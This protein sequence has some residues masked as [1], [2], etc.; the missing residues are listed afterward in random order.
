MA[1]ALPSIP[2]STPIQNRPDYARAE[3]THAKPARDLCGALMLGTS[4]VR[5]LGKIGLPKWPAEKEEH[6]KIRAAISQ[7]ARYYQRTVQASVGMICATPPALNKDA[8]PLLLADAEDIDGQG[9]H[10]EVFSKHLTS[11]AITGGFSAILVDAPPIPEGMSLSLADEQALGIRPF[12]VPIPADRIVSWIV[13]TPKFADL[14]ALWS[15]GLITSDQVKSAAKQTLLRQVVI[16]EPTDVTAGTYGTVCK[17][18]Y[19]ALRLTDDGVT[20]EV[21]EKRTSDGATGEHFALIASGP[22]YA[23]GRQA[24]REIPLA[25]VYGGRKVAPF[26]AEPALMA[27][28]ELN[29]DHYQVSADRRYL[30]RLCHAPTLTTIGLVEAED[31]NGRPKPINVGPNSLLMLP[32]GGDA[33]YVAADPAALDSSKAEREEL[34]KQ[35]AVLGM[36]FIGKD[37]RSNTETATGRALDAAAENA[38]HAT[39]ARGLQD[40]LEQAWRYMAMYRGVKAPEVTVNTTYANADADPQV[41]QI[42]WLAVAA[43]QL[44]IDALIEYLKTGSLPDDL[45]DGVDTLRFI[46]NESAAAADVPDP[47]IPAAKIPASMT[48]KVVRGKD[49]KV[50]RLVSSAA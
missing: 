4:G 43:G 10:L 35:M 17:D 24:F 27:L 44:P 42:I 26:V 21:W 45:Q 2:T 19:R 7:V 20:F 32:L 36:S 30:M 5:A 14:L 11:D 40:G 12:M 31:E 15:L 16:H 48:H 9:T 34:V 50:K 37:K 49:G 33:K 39:V 3:Y 23:A 18:R 29:L 13:E 38:S 25:I 1:D 47:A 41:A 8:D 46:A 6:Y 22:M 28:A